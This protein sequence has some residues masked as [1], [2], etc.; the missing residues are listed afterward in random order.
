MAGETTRFLKITRSVGLFGEVQLTWRQQVKGVKGRR[1]ITPS[2]GLLT[3]NEYDREK[4]IEIK[5][6]KDDVPELAMN[7]TLELKVL[8]GKLFIYNY[9]III[10]IDLIKTLLIYV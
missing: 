5:V 9:S 1:Q 4:E 6:L 3:F 2:N 7:I 10:I 8:S